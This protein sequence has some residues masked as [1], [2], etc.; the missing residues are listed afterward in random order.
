M[1]RETSVTT[2][3][4][5][6]PICRDMFDNPKSLPCLHAYCLTCI[7]EY[8][9]DMY[10]GDEVP[11]PVCRKDFKIPE[12]GGLDSLQHHFFIQRLVDCRKAKSNAGFSEDEVLCEMCLEQNHEGATKILPATLRC[13][14]C[15]QKLCYRCSKFHRR[16]GGDHQIEPLDAEA[17]QELLQLRGLSCDNHRDKRVELYCHDCNENICLTCSSAKHRNHSG[18]EIPEAANNFRLRI[19]DDDK[20]ILSAVGSL[21][22]QSRQTKQD[23]AKFMSKVENMK[24][25]VIVSGDEVRRLVDDRISDVLRELESLISDSDKEITSLQE[26]YQLA[27]TSMESFHA[28]SRELLDKGR[29]SD[30]TRAACELHD[31]ANEL[32]DNVV[33]AAQYRPPHVTFA[34][35]DVMQVYRLNLIGKVTIVNEDQP[36]T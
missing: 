6:C 8:C 7:Q 32:L 1:E 22:R 30:I 17:D 34:P 4:T 16:M 18:I 26:R 2:D 19:D 9:K 36:G 25:M 11:C 35:A 24:R 12:E 28:Y 13:V 21:R 15:N 10:P 23:A 5:T 27:L 31:R 33:T 3:L 20:K 29:P 14:D